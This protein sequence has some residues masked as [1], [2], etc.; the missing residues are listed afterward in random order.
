MPPVSSWGEL[1]RMHVVQVMRLEC[2]SVCTQ[3]YDFQEDP[4]HGCSVHRQ[5][6]GSA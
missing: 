6:G 2:V 3:R 1:G 5:E 4:A